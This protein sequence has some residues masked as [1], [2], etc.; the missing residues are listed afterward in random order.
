MN[1]PFDRD[2]ERRENERMWDERERRERRE[3]Y[4]DSVRDLF[5]SPPVP[6]TPS[7]PSDNQNHNP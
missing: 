5:R 1:R 2:D 6:V 7:L 3:R 4:G